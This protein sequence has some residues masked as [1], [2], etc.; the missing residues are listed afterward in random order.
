MTALGHTPLP[1]TNTQHDVIMN[2]T[3][4]TYHS[5]PPLVYATLMPAELFIGSNGYC[6]KT[7][8]N[9]VCIIILL[10]LQQNHFRG[11]LTGSIHQF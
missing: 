7:S 6:N 10:S 5:I 1:P 9:T 4:E 3:H 8:F 2:V 11:S